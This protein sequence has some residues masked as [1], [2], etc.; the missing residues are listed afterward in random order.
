[1]GHVHSELKRLADIC[2]KQALDVK[3]Y[4][5]ECEKAQKDAN[6]AVRAQTIMQYLMEEK[7]LQSCELKGTINS[8]CSRLSRIQVVRD[9]VQLAQNKVSILEHKVK[10]MESQESHAMGLMVHFL[11]RRGYKDAPEPPP[12]RNETLEAAGTDESVPEIM[13]GTGKL[14]NR[15]MGRDEV[16]RILE[17]IWKDKKRWE[18]VK[19]TKIE[20]GPHY[21]G[22]LK[23][24]FGVVGNTTGVGSLLI[25]EH[26]YSLIDACS[27]FGQSDFELFMYARLLKSE[28]PDEIFPDMKKKISDFEAMLKKM[29]Q[30]IP[31]VPMKVPKKS[32][33]A[34]DYAPV[35][36]IYEVIEQIWDAKSE[37]RLKQL[38]F[39]V[40]LFFND[41]DVST[42]EPRGYME[43]VRLTDLLDKSGKFIETLKCQQL[44]EYD[45]F[46]EEIRQAIL[47]GHPTLGPR[48]MISL[49]DIY[50][51]FIEIDPRQPKSLV[52]RM[53]LMAAGIVTPNMKK[54]MKFENEYQDLDELDREIEFHQFFASFR[55]LCYMTKCT[56]I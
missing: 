48:D 47:V 21:V 9:Q 42:E 44:E 28:I 34:W 49:L 14:K 10:I 55:R 38:H 53:I 26:V 41:G 16:N 13:R 30:S 27:I 29:N 32:K 23:Q 22:M 11:S 31:R 17:D 35:P 19:Q 43:W 7:D 52:K 1:M 5:S 51:K 18:S 33:A 46:V 6:D 25:L 39:A 20:F 45:E 8:L 3:Q 56:K 37:H 50:H 2:E 54:S 4:G 15:M 36:L 24:K 40:M 12:P